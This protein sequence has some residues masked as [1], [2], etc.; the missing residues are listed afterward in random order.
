MADLSA[1]LYGTPQPQQQAPSGNIPDFVYSLSPRDQGEWLTN[2]YKEA[3]KRIKELDDQIS[4]AASTLSDLNTFGRYNRNTS[5]GGILSAV[6][7]NSGWMRSDDIN[8]MNSIT[9]RLA[10]SARPAGSGSS[11]DRDV[12]LFLQSLPSVEQGGN[13]NKQIRQNFQKSYD[14][15]LAKK[16]AMQDYLT[17]NG[18]LIGFDSQW[19]QSPEYQA[20][21]AG[22]Q[23]RTLNDIV[24]EQLNKRNKGAK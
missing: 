3:Q 9:S 24:N 16:T 15:A 2:Q 10:P 13:A 6:L 21:M 11:S 7:P 19:N 14:Y 20:Y 22:G 18:H 1:L 5:T 8:A 23:Q 12:S 17:K 4:P